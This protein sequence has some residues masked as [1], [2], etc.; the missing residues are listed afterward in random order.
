MKYTKLSLHGKFPAN[1]GKDS[2]NIFELTKCGALL[3]FFSENDKSGI[4]IK[5]SPAFSSKKT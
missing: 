4:L 2:K 5:E 3:R 1:G